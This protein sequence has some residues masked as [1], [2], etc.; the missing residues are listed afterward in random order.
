MIA[1]PENWSAEELSW[2]NHETAQVVSSISQLSRIG[3]IT[4]TIF[5]LVLSKTD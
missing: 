4:L 5:P 2:R 3:R 1:L